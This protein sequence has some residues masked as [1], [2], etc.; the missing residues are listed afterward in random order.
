MQR[1]AGS[2][3]VVTVTN[4][5]EFFRGALRGALADHRIAVE[6]QTEHYV[7]N[8]LTLFARAERLYDSTPDGPRLKP[9]AQMLSEALCAA[10]PAER[11]SALQRL[12]D[13]S[14]FMAGLFARGFARRLVD[15]DYHIAMGGRAYSALALSHERGRR[16]ALAQVF[17]ELAAK[18]QPLVDALGEIGDAA[19]VY[20]QRDILRLY[21]IWL[22]TGSARARRLLRRLGIEAAPVAMRTH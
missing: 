5:M 10:T 18:F 9:L 17:G 13:I 6:E 14:L 15:V 8:M 7:V 4:L 12:G 16:R 20:T 3:S 21:E 22:K 19:F 1:D 2:G 11:E